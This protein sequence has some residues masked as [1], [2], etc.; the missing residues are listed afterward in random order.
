MKRLDWSDMGFAAVIAALLYLFSWVLVGGISAEN[1]RF[2]P[3]PDGADYR[4]ETHWRG[5]GIWMIP[6]TYSCWSES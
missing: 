4:H 5:M 2:E 3:C 6:D 1:V